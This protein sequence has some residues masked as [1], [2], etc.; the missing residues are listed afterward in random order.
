MEDI[1]I[2]IDYDEIKIC[3]TYSYLDE[4]FVHTQIVMRENILDKDLWLEL[5]ES[6]KDSNNV[7]LESE[8]FD[9]KEEFIKI[10]TSPQNLLYTFTNEIEKKL[11]TDMDTDTNNQYILTPFYCELHDEV[12]LFEGDLSMV[13]DNFQMFKN[14]DWIRIGY[15][16]INRDKVSGDIHY[17]WNKYYDTGFHLNMISRVETCNGPLQILEHSA[18]KDWLN[19]YSYDRTK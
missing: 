3:K 1:S 17:D 14:C 4:L 8:H 12:F 7:V 2:E 6:I 9:S 15:I 19:S 13:P 16:I 5:C 10:Q 18:L 11:D